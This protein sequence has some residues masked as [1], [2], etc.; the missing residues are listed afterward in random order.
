V[1]RAPGIPHALCFPGRMILSQ[2]GRIVP[3]D[4]EAASGLMSLR[5]ASRPP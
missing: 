2:L 3:R 1:Q 5:E 4:S